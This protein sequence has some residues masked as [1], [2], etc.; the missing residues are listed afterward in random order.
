MVIRLGKGS[1]LCRR[2]E[3]V[4]EDTMAVDEKGVGKEGRKGSASESKLL[5]FILNNSLEFSNT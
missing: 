5:C 4:E 1:E 2:A 3:M